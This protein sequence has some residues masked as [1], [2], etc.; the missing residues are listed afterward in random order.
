MGRTSAWRSAAA[1]LAAAL[2]LA[3][4]EKVTATGHCPQLCPADS[5]VLVDTILT[6]IVSA[7]T[8][9][10]GYTRLDVG[11]ILLASTRDSIDARPMMTFIALP[12]RW[13][14]VGA[15]TAGVPIG[16]VD[17]VVVVVHMNERDTTAKS[18][19]L[20]LFHFPTTLDSTTTYDSVLA[21]WT[22][23]FDSIQIP[24][25]LRTADVR[26]LITDS[27]TIAN[28]WVPLASDSF[29]LA[30]GM[31][32]TADR[33]TAVILASGDES[34]TPPRISF[35]VHGAAP[36]DTFAN[37]FDLT[38]TFD[39]YVQRP[40][41]PQ[42]VSDA[43]DFGNHPAARS[44]LRFQ[45]PSYFVDTVSV[46]RATLVLTLTSPVT[47]IPG[48]TVV[49]TAEAILRYL[50]GKSVL[51]QDTTATGEGHALVGQTTPVEI[52]L[53]NI[54]HVWHGISTDSL[55]RDI[56]LHNAL[57]GFIYSEIKASGHNAGAA[58]PYLKL[59][60]V[61]PFRFGVP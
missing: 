23:P 47:G 8:S 14:P 20:R 49:L 44:F 58:A 25:S 56:T 16:K 24:D 53:A 51:F 7:D 36:Q 54:L 35:F 41:P 27:A 60:F 26:L 3:C 5:L 12:Q 59:S 48:D 2:A 19:Y 17:S 37:E 13:F 4:T 15:D 45:I 40:D 1:A 10:R 34:G 43:I 18:T 50:D 21:L 33:P 11:D 39:S 31:T 61:R 6:G 52:E 32:V 57:E 28:N 9:L 30:L 38:P 29:R 22:T 46:V 55:P 42:P